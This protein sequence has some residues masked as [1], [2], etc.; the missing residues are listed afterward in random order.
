MKELLRGYYLAHM[1]LLTS[2][3]RIVTS[4]WGGVDPGDATRSWSRRRVGEQLFV[5]VSLAQHAAASAA[6]E[7]VGDA[8]REQNHQPDPSGVVQPRA[9]AGVASDGRKLE[10]LLLQPLI[11]VEAAVK[12]GADPELAHRRAGDTLDRIARSEVTDAGQVA[13]TTAI[14]ADR[15]VTGWV[16][17]LA[18]G[19]CGRCAILAGKH[20]R[21]N[22]GFLRHPGCRC[23][24]VPAVEDRADEVMTDPHLYFRSLSE[25]DQ[26]RLFGAGGAEAIRLGADI[27]KVV[28]VQ[29]RN[30]GL[31]VAGRDSRVGR[32]MPAALI[33][34]AGGDRDEAIRLLTAFGYI[35][36]T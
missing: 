17:M 13:E 22:A 3:S 32:S 33:R 15:S 36:G 20:Y 26:N 18:P 14:T 30:A 19:S 1:G 11:E 8:V 10:S 24:H 9:L 35:R 12:A 29:T 5:A 31:G 23:R 34:R 21:W 6:V 16:R 7:F 25:A 27:F 2:L 28:N 4:L